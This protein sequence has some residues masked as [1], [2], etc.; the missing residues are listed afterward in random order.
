[1]S[2]K[3]VYVCD[4]CK[5]TLDSEADLLAML[6]IAFDFGDGCSFSGDACKPCLERLRRGVRN[7][8]LYSGAAEWPSFY[9]PTTTTS[10]SEDRT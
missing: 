3:T 8:R 6:A 4:L 7:T 9:P 1:M 2:R 5:S 10:E